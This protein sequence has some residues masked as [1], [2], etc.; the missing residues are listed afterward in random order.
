[1]RGFANGL[2]SVGQVITD[3]ELI[4][5]ILEGLGSDYETDVVNLTSR[6]NVTIREVQLMLQNQEMRLENLN[7]AATMDL[8]NPSIRKIIYISKYI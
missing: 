1:M 6:E 5:Y 7:A 4:L 8:H 3:K 2:L